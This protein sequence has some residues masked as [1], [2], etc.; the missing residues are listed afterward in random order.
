MN[1]S[2][3]KPNTDGVWLWSEFERIEVVVIYNNAGMFFIDGADPF[4]LSELD[5]EKLTGLWLGPLP[6]PAITA[7]VDCP[8]CG[9][10]F[11]TSYGV[12][13]Q[14]LHIALRR[15]KASLFRFLADSSSVAKS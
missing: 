1:W 4:P 8:Q 11:Q 3:Q 5:S 7:P 14:A 15:D 2:T 6:L 13:Y 9:K 12:D 10:H